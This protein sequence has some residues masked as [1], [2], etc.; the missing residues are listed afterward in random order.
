LGVEG[1]DE[2]LLVWVALSPDDV[3][4]F[5]SHHKMINTKPVN[6]HSPDKAAR[7]SRFFGRG[8]R[9]TYLN[10]RTRAAFVF[11][12]VS[13]RPSTSAAGLGMRV[14]KVAVPPLP[15]ELCELSRTESSQRIFR[16]GGDGITEDSRTACQIRH[17][18]YLDGREVG[19]DVDG[20][21]VVRFGRDFR[22]R[23]PPHMSP[24]ADRDD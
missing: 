12:C 1:H 13:T 5:L 10:T 15:S 9:I 24:A 23:R 14:G 7:L 4:E 16:R 17:V 11:S 19:F 2:Y 6:K 3:V 18:K 21:G 20:S 8:V 22:R